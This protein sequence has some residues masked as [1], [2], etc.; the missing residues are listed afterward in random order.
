MPPPSDTVASRS[1]SL[2][3]PSAG[4]VE[5][6]RRPNAHPG[7]G[8][9]LGGQQG[10]KQA[11]RVKSVGC[12]WPPTSINL[13]RA[14]GSISSLIATTGPLVPSPSVKPTVVEDLSI[15]STINRKMVS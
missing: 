5:E 10:V 12:L 4:G 3:C 7:Q 9:L 2:F 6:R 8:L 1:S 13:S 11:S 14:P 15:P